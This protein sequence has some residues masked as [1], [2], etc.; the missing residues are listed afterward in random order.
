[1]IGMEEVEENGANFIG[2]E[3]P[4]FEAVAGGKNCGPQNGTRGGIA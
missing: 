1:M 4:R 3:I 2:T